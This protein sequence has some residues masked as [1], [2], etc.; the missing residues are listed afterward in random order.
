MNDL[1]AID[2]SPFSKRRHPEPPPHLGTRYDR[3]G[4]F[5]RE[6][7]NTVVSH[8]VD[9]SETQKVLV[10]ARQRYLD[11]TEA[12]QLAFT[13]VSSLHMTIF[14]GVIEYRRKSGFWPPDLALDMPIDETTVRLRERLREFT[15]EPPFKVHV[16]EALPTGLTLDGITAADRKALRDWRDALADIFGY[17]HPDHD[18]YRFHITFAYVIQRFDDDALTSWQTMLEQVVADIR[19]RLDH[20]ELRPPAF[21]SFEDM[22]HFE[23]LVVLAC[24]K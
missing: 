23:E 19:Q 20:V 6:P 13:P 11:M 17:R 21:C 16:V 18:S 9:G 24:G 22:N 10:E 14:Q 15:G 3:S 7:G 12:A 5:L 4:S 1:P 8:V 2:L